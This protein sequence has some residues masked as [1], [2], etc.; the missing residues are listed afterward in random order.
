MIHGLRNRSNIDLLS[1][2]SVHLKRLPNLY[3]HSFS[4][5]SAIAPETGLV[6]PTYLDLF[7]EPP[8]RSPCFLSTDVKEDD[9]I[10][11]D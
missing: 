1:N 6:D 2:T 7:R 5:I 9:L 8:F 3:P 4:S 10:N 11:Y